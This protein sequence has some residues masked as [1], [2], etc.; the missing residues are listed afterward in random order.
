MAQLRVSEPIGLAMNR[1]ER[2]LFK[3][4]GGRKKWMTLG[5]AAWLASINEWRGLGAA[6][7][8]IPRGI[9]YVIRSPDEFSRNMEA[10][11]A[12]LLL[13]LLAIT[14]VLFAVYLL[15]RWLNCRGQFMLLE[16]VMEDRLA[17]KESWRRQRALANS[18]LK[19]RIG[20]DLIIFNIFLVIF[21]MAGVLIWQD[22]R[23]ML[24]G[25]DYAA[26]NWTWSGIIIGAVGTFLAGVFIVLATL[27]IDYFMVPVMF[28]RNLP[29]TAAFRLALWNMFWPNKKTCL[30]FLLMMMLAEMLHGM[31]MSAATIFIILITCGIGLAL[32]LI[33][34]LSLLPLYPAA[35]LAL[36][37]D[38]FSRAYCL[39]FLEQFGPEYRPAWRDTAGVP[40]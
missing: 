20:W 18:L 31:A 27:F 34:L 15:F 25:I 5:V 26:T 10:H 17:V 23:P 6:M 19:F 12:A 39:H 8:S 22:I 35:T 24:S 14:L 38:V 29:A 3:P 28:L 2:M 30:G 32:M 11:R 33:P 1:A 16:A 40:V 7:E 9:L 4:G 21:V 37:F 36:A 13:W